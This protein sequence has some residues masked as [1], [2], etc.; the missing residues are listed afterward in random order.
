MSLSAL[1][2]SHKNH[3]SATAPKDLSDNKNAAELQIVLTEINGL[4]INLIKQMKIDSFVEIDA[5]HLEIFRGVDGIEEAFPNVHIVQPKV[6]FLF[7]DMDLTEIKKAYTESNKL[8]KEQTEK[9]QVK[10][11]LQQINKINNKAILLYY[12][13]FHNTLNSNRFTMVENTVRRVG[14]ALQSLDIC[15]LVSTN[16]NPILFEF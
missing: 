12:V 2:Y 16:G 9:L 4:Y 3:W 10:D 6:E 14:A 13:D 1:V 7:K 15:G 5:N 11:I 8:T